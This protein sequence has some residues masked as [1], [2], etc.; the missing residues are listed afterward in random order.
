M[1]EEKLKGVQPL[2]IELANLQWTT[3]KWQ[4]WCLQNNVGV[5]IEDGRITGWDVK[6][7]RFHK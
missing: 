7:Q 6:E 1:R 2:D 4:K 5:I 3:A